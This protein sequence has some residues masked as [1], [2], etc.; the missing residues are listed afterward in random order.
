MIIDVFIG[1]IFFSSLLRFLTLRSRASEL[2]FVLI[3]YSFFCL[4][5][6]GFLL[7]SSGV[8]RHASHFFQQQKK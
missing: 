8:A 5:Y 6:L 7:R 3:L 2:P 1:F 4:V